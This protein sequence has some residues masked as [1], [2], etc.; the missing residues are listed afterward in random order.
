MFQAIAARQPA[1]LERDNPGTVCDIFLA[2]SVFSKLTNCSHQIE[3]PE[4]IYKEAFSNDSVCFITGWAPSSESDKEANLGVV[5]IY[6]P[7]LCSE[8]TR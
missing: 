1:T 6:P 8:V 4:H 5:W 2:A 3:M 7:N